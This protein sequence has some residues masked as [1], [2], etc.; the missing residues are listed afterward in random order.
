MTNQNSSLEVEL[1]SDQLEIK[2]LA[3]RCLA[4]REYSKHELTQKLFRQSF[5]SSDIEGV[6]QDLIKKDFLSD[7]RFADLIIRS[8]ISALCGP[9]KIKIELQEKGVD[10]ATVETLLAHYE[11]DWYSLA[12]KAK[13]KRFGAA[14]PED[15]KALSKQIRY[16]KNKGFYQEHIS[17]LFSA[18]DI[19]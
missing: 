5:E 3:M 16:L 18:A 1:S 4:R 13:E 8:R 6:L 11:V 7:E 15:S 9:F 17:G 12:R 19:F 2:R 14:E 10:E